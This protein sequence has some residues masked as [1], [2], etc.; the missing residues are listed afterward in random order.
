MFFFDDSPD[1]S[2]EQ[3]IADNTTKCQEFYVMKK[4]NFP[5]ITQTLVSIATHLTAIVTTY[6]IGK[7]FLKDDFVD[8][9]AYFDFTGTL[10]RGV[11]PYLLE[12][13]SLNWADPPIVFPGYTAFMLPLTLFPLNVA[14]LIFLSINVLLPAILFYLLFRITNLANSSEKVQFAPVRSGFLLTTLIFMNTIPYTACIKHGQIS[15]IISTML[16]VTLL[17]KSIYAKILYFSLAAALKYSMIPLY[18][19]MLFIKR[20]FLLCI[21]AFAMFLIWAIVPI[22]FGHNLQDLYNNYISTLNKQLV[23]GGFNTFPVSGYNMLQPDFFKMGQLCTAIK[24]TFLALFFTATVINRKQK[25]IGLHLLLLVS[26]ITMVISYHRVYDMVFALPIILVLINIYLRKKRYFDTI[27]LSCF[28][29]YF[30]IPETIVF[31]FAG[32]VGKMFTEN[33]IIYSTDFASYENIFP[34]TPIV[35]LLL[36]MYSFWLFCK[37]SLFLNKEKDG[38]ITGFEIGNL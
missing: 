24:L 23:I 21:T 8:F 33:P 34:L 6:R 38:I 14:K 36:A 28:V 5:E 25:Q 18:G 16:I 13:L 2:G 30:L 29:G 37:E 15:M 17:S 1:I 10:I 9:N 32:F 4:R 12:N 22:F 20:K 11:N 7:V 35:C 26:T 3:R 31:K 27:I 19:M